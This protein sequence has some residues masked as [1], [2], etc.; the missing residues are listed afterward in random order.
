MN[1]FYVL[2]ENKNVRLATIL[3]WA[4]YWGRSERFLA[5]TKIGETK[6][7]TAFIGTDE[8]EMMGEEVSDPPLVF[9][10]YDFETEEETFSATYEEALQEHARRVRARQH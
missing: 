1:R 4:E 7:V 8:R 10:T 5:S 6:I 9:G 2:D 3:E